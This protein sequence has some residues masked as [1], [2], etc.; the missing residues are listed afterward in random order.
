MTDS[1][2]G[3]EARPKD[4]TAADV[5]EF[6]ERLLQELSTDPATGSRTARKQEHQHAAL[7][8]VAG[9]K[10]LIQHANPDHERVAL[11]DYMNL[12]RRQAKLIENDLRAQ[13]QKHRRQ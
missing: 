1:P 13:G 6:V 8:L 3:A 11:V 2:A 9:A 10:L 7:C 5:A 4:G 12:L